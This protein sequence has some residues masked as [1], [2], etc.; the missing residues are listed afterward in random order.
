M[1]TKTGRST[2]QQVTFSNA[3]ASSKIPRQS[4]AKTCLTKKRK[5]TTAR[6][7]EVKIFISP[8]CAKAVPVIGILLSLFYLFETTYCLPI[9]DSGFLFIGIFVV[10]IYG[11]YTPHKI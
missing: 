3:S 8:F 4:V 5:E 11:K 6:K 9:I 2:S 7:K 10:N 1:P